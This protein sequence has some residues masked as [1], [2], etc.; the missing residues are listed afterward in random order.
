MWCRRG[1]WDASAAA[2]RLASHDQGITSRGSASTSSSESDGYDSSG[3]EC[4]GGGSAHHGL[5]RDE[6]QRMQGGVHAAGHGC[7]GVTVTDVANTFH[8]H[9]NYR[10]V[11]DVCFLGPQSQWVASGSDDGRLFVWGAESGALVLMQVGLP[12][13]ECLALRTKP[14]M[15]AG[16]HVR[17]RLQMCACQHKSNSNEMAGC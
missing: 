11:K 9:L 7:A 1:F 6:G 10:T 17:P 3:D 13:E 16:S 12:M 2:A 14:Q 8:G 4:E 15:L 5:W